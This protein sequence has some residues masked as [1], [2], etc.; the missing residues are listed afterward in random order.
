[1]SLA[2]LLA[3]P[4]GLFFGWRIV[5]LGALANALGA[6]IYSYGFSVFFLPISRD[7]DLTRAQTSFIF[8]LSQ[9]EGAISGPPAGWVVDRFGPRKVITAATIGSGIGYIVLSQVTDYAMFLLV[10]LGVISLAYNGGYGLAVTSSVNSWFIRKRSLAFSLTLSAFNLG[11]AVVGPALAI[12][13]QHIGW[14]GAVAVAG[15]VLM[16][17]ML[18]A[19]Q[20]FVSTPEELGMHPDGEPPPEAGSAAAARLS[21][22]EFTLG[23][24]LR[25]GA[26]WGLTFATMLRLAVINVLTLHFVPIMVWK[27][28]S[29]PDGAFMLGAFA[30]LGIPLRILMGWI[31]DRTSKT[32]LIATGLLIGTGGLVELILADQPWQ[33]WLFVVVLACMNSI[34]PLNWALIGDFFGRRNYAS[35]RGF[36]GMV[37]TF[38]TMA[39]PVFAGAV[40]DNTHSYEFVLLTC[41]LLF[42]ASAVWFARLRPPRLAPIPQPVAGPA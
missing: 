7:L 5:A 24:A 6:G 9:A 30:L 21:S 41:T 12:L 26:F 1:M 11:G 23:Q 29:E 20:G 8:S 36:M 37:Y 38:G 14:R 3:I 31:G 13:V 27:G 39:M 25:T 42:F 28:V 15:V 35:V 22:N 34:I 32:G 17:V 10:Y 2:R 16:L 19:A 33:L 4:G 18:P 40:Y